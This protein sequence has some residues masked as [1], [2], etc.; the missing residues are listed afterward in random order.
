[1]GVVPRPPASSPAAQLVLP[2][3]R[4]AP[5][6]PA[7]TG[8]PPAPVAAYRPSIGTWR[9]LARSAACPS[10]SASVSGCPMRVSGM[11]WRPCARAGRCG[12]GASAP[13]KAEL[14]ARSGGGRPRHGAGAGAR[15]DADV[16]D[17][18]RVDALLHLDADSLRRSAA[19]VA[20]LSHRGARRRERESGLPLR[21]RARGLAP[22]GCCGCC[23]SPARPSAG[24]RGRCGGS[25]PG[26]R[27]GRCARCQPAVDVGEGRDEQVRPT[28]EKLGVCR[29]RSRALDDTG[30]AVLRG[31]GSCASI[32]RQREARGQL[33]RALAFLLN[34]LYPEPTSQAMVSQL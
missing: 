10:S 30:L 2:S 19:Q 21:G 18:A 6:P 4:R 25:S 1:M 26:N 22:P 16:E 20:R 7:A 34:S 8:G 13:L 32:W 11:S 14:E 28:G 12:Q 15:L 33:R 3:R 27:S 29:L 31:L 17:A 5:P 23:N 24:R 9:N